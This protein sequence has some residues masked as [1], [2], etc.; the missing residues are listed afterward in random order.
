ML[1]FISDNATRKFPVARYRL[2]TLYRL[3]VCMCL[4][5]ISDIV[6]LAL[7][8]A[9]PQIVVPAQSEVAPWSAMSADDDACGPWTGQGSS[10]WEGASSSW[11]AWSW[12]D[13]SSWQGQSSSSW[14]GTSSWQDASRSSSWQEESFDLRPCFRCGT[15]SYTKNDMCVNKD[16]VHRSDAPSEQARADVEGAS[17]GRVEKFLVSL[18]LLT[19]TRSLGEVLCY[20]YEHCTARSLLTRLVSVAI[21]RCL[22]VCFR[23]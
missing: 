2:G 11:G 20:L 1:K 15:R 8:L 17:V 6:T 23:E 13:A 16:C 22:G 14:Q 18:S 10:S 21:Q 4:S 3:C 12:Q 19:T 9:A 7:R 5:Q